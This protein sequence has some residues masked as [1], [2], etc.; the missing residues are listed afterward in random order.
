ME[1]CE[2]HFKFKVVTCNHLSNNFWMSVTWFLFRPNAP[3]LQLAVLPRG[4]PV[5][6]PSTGE[7]EQKRFALCGSETSD[8]QYR[9]HRKCFWHGNDSPNT[10]RDTQMMRHGSFTHL[11]GIYQTYINIYIYYYIYIYRYVFI[12]TYIC[13]SKPGW[14][15]LLYVCISRRACQ[16]THHSHISTHTIHRILRHT[17]Q[18]ISILLHLHVSRDTHA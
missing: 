7:W 4:L 1:R 11:S 14:F 2:K 13:A 15:T 6:E 16:Y 10:A 5:A 9:K 18:N 3:L 8:F 12:N 17:C